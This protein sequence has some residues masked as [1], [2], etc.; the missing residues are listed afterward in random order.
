MAAAAAVWWR[1]QKQT[2]GVPKGKRESFQTSLTD[3]TVFG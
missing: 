1:Q 3:N 2:D